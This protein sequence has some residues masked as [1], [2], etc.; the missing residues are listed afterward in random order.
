MIVFVYDTIKNDEFA[1][2]VKSVV[3]FHP[4]WVSETQKLL[5]CGQLMVR[6][7]EENQ[8]GCN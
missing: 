3:Y 1:D 2:P 5:L 7:L 4:S 6:E 8:T